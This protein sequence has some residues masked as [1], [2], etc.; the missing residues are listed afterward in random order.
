MNLADKAYDLIRRD[1]ITCVLQPGQ[2]IAQAQLADMYAVGTTP[3]REALQRLA[4]ENLVSP[5]PRSGY[6]VS[7]ITFVDIRELFELRAVL[8]TSAV[9][10]AALRASEDQLRHILEKANFKYVYNDREDYTRF[11]TLNAD[12]HCSI[13]ALGG[14]QR[15]TESLSR[16]LDEL[17]R[18]FHLGLD[19]KDSAEEMREEH[20]GLAKALVA[21]DDDL[22]VKLVRAQISRSSER[23]VEAVMSRVHTGLTGAAS[24]ITPIPFDTVFIGE[25]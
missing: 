11:L 20:L 18:V 8:E 1:I 12:F 10:M 2:Q 19:L 16:I 5:V 25:T 7:P 22:A 14:N 15:L 17:T 4:H 23:V 13:A 24:P 3:I 9:R 6:V 21:R